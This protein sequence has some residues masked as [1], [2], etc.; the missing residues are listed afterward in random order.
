MILFLPWQSFASFGLKSGDGKHQGKLPLLQITEPLIQAVPRVQSRGMRYKGINSSSFWGDQ[1]V[2][3]SSSWQG[4]T[5]SSLTLWLMLC[6]D[7]DEVFLLSAPS[8]QGF[9][10]GFLRFCGFFVCSASLFLALGLI[11]ER[12]HFS[13]FRTP[14][15]LLEWLSPVSSAEPPESLTLLLICSFH[16]VLNP[17]C[18]SQSCGTFRESPSG[19][20]GASWVLLEVCALMWPLSPPVTWTHH[21]L[22]CYY[23]SNTW[24]MLLVFL[25]EKNPLGFFFSTL[26]PSKHHIFITS[27]V[28]IGKYL[29]LLPRF[30]KDSLGRIYCLIF[31]YFWDI[32]VSPWVLREAQDL[33]LCKVMACFI[34]V[35]TR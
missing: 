10:Q 8:S 7:P 21:S 35:P 22:R 16:G 31:Q 33:C 26:I 9:S 5:P 28:I 27:E 20:P 23:C 29:I 2:G 13:E 1:N 17:P 34:L 24:A 12:K 32:F 18:C 15:L 25:P 14:S 30:N 6:P 19:F 11:C 4:A 3:R